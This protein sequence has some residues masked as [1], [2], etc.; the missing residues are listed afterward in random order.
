M[1]DLIETVLVLV[2]IFL[3]APVL[4]DLLSGGER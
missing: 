1:S 4:A 2:G 3:A